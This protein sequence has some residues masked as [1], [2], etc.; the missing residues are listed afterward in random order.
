LEL[1]DPF[2]TAAKALDEMQRQHDAI[3]E[4]LAVARDLCAGAPPE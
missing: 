4:A 3:A 1:G 2:A